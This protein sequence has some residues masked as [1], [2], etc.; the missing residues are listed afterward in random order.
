MLN[1]KLWGPYAWY[2]F[3]TVTYAYQTLLAD[4]YYYFF[5]LLP[6]I[7]PCENCGQHYQAHIEKHPP[8]TQNQEALVNWL[9]DVHNR[10]NKFQKKPQLTSEEAYPLYHVDGQLVVNHHYIIDLISI[11]SVPNHYS[12]DFINFLTTL[13]IIFPCHLCRQPLMELEKQPLTNEEY[14]RQYLD[15]L[16]AHSPT[17][18]E[19]NRIRQL[20]FYVNPAFLLPDK[21][22]VPAPAP[23]PPKRHHRHRSPEEEFK[24][25][26]KKAIRSIKRVNASASGRYITRLSRAIG[27]GKY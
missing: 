18:E 15:L 12:T 2:L 25:E 21:A 27:R 20:G 14:V 5:H 13:A 23:T 9:I 1:P 17:E 10:V 19:E 16:Y 24:R 26:I 22:L 11:L 7:F 8:P 3:H 6:R 4:Y